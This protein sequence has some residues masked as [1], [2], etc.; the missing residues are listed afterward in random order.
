MKYFAFLLVGLLFLLGP[1]AAQAVPTPGELDRIEAATRVFNEMPGRIPAYVP[2]NAKGIAVI[3]G[4]PKAA[5]I[6][7]GELVGGVIVSRLPDR[8][9]SSP[10]LISPAGMRFGLQVGGE[11]RDIMLVFNTARSM[12]F[13]ESGRIKLGADASVAAGPVGAGT[14][15]TTDIPEVYAYVRSLGA[16]IG[17]SL[18][19]GC[20]RLIPVRTWTFTEFPIR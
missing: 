7:G 11:A 19:G 1:I 13:I 20:C 8:S 6:F 17:V 18:E 5:L 10:A 12:D 14:G 4:E 2:D 3:P 16:F 9:W 15:V